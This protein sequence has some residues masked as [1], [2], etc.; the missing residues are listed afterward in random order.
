MRFFNPIPD[1]AVLLNSNGWYWEAPLYE[2][3]SQMF[4]KTGRK[5]IRVCPDNRT[6]L[7]K[8]F[9]S[10]IDSGSGSYATQGPHLVWFP[11]LTQAAE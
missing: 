10:R 1:G 3:D 9:W 2:R 5:F 7:P 4:V 11:P 8:T 6:S